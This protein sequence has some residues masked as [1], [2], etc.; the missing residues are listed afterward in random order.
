MHNKLFESQS[1]W[2]TLS[3]ADRGNYFTDA[4]KELGL[5]IDTFNTD[6]AG[7]NVT[8]KISFDQAL[9]KKDK[10]S[11]TPTVFLNG[12]TVELSILNDSAKLE[13]LLKSEMKKQNIEVPAETK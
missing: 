7:V 4:A 2:G 13:E 8:K 3:A 10:V 6:M 12:Q 9:G 1:A 11:G 5:N